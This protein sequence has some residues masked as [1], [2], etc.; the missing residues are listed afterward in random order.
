MKKKE[1]IFYDG[2]AFPSTGNTLELK[3]SNK[4]T[5]HGMGYMREIQLNEGLRMFQYSFKI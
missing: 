5:D 4:G 2:N 3:A 1:V